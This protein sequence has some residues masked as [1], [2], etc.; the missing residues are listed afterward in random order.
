MRATRWTL[1]DAASAI[2]SPDLHHMVGVAVGVPV[3]VVDLGPDADANETDRVVAELTALPAVIVTTGD[4]RDERGDVHVDDPDPVV[5]ATLANPLAAVTATQVL[6]GSEG[7]TLAEGLLVESLAYATL[8]SGPEHRAW[9]AGQGRRVRSD[10]AEP[11]IRIVDHGSHVEIVFTRPRL[12]N[13]IDAAMR[14]QL[15][16]ALK[17]TAVGAPRSIR[18][19][20]DG[21]TFCGGGDPAEFGTVADPATGHAVRSTAG[22]AP[23]LSLVAE[24][25]TAEIR[26]ACVGAGVELIAFCGRV[27]ATEDA[28]FQLPEVAMGLLPGTGGTISVPARIGRQRT[29]E[30]LLTANEIDAVTALEWGVVDQIV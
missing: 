19:G 13:L 2:A 7:R 23:W 17:A 6:R 22:I 8:Q 14:D 18:L 30:W 3:V 27:E 5:A 12:H 10:D 16:D 20:A 9:Q 11:R 24:R 26:G 29:L 1:G 28:R 21:P 4:R 25:V 15:V